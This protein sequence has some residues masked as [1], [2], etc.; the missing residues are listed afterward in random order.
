MTNTSAVLMDEEHLQETVQALST[1]SL[2]QQG[3]I[4][5][6]VA[7][8][9]AMLAVLCK[10]TPAQ[11]PA[12]AAHL[13][14]SARDHRHEDWAADQRDAFDNHIRRLQTLLLLLQ[15]AGMLRA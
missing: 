5:A 7:A 4:M 1:L 10:A 3:Q 2:C 14:V 11:A 15:K 13:D 9:D 12:L 8:V 6:L